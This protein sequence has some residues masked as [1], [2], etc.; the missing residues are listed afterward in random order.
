MVF[1]MVLCPRYNMVCHNATVPV[2]VALLALYWF[3]S[4]LVQ[5]ELTL[6]FVIVSCPSGGI[7]MGVGSHFHVVGC[8]AGCE[9]S[10]HN[11]KPRGR[12]P[13]SLVGLESQS[14]SC[15]PHPAVGGTIHPSRR[16]A[17]RRDGVCLVLEDSYSLSPGGVIGVCLPLSE[18]AYLVELDLSPFL[19][20]SG[21]R[22]G[23][24]V[25]HCVQ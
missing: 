21:R 8:P 9:A 5:C 13:V 3:T 4:C 22:R 25:L 15:E 20:R 14:R 2:M 18:Q 10:D 1:V 7:S 17:W 24:A 23:R 11:P 16:A 19:P 6:P 12:G